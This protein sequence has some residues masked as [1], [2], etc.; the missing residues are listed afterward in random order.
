ME[1]SSATHIAPSA[2]RGGIAIGAI[3]TA[4]AAGHHVARLAQT[5]NLHNQIAVALGVTPPR[6]MGS[7]ILREKILRPKSAWQWLNYRPW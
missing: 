7:F 5:L 1:S 3:E 6:E 4:L 2:G